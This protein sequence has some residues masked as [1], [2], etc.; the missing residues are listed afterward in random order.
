LVR[1]NAVISQHEGQQESWGLSFARQSLH[2]NFPAVTKSGCISAAAFLNYYRASS[3]P[4]GTCQY[5][6]PIFSLCCW[7]FSAHLCEA[8]LSENATRANPPALKIAAN[9][10]ILRRITTSS[11]LGEALATAEPHQHDVMMKTFL[12]AKRGSCDEEVTRSQYREGKMA[13]K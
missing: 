6:L 4:P 5:A 2:F 3:L 13:H 11:I 1:Y 7:A 10:I 12:R 8:S 9:G